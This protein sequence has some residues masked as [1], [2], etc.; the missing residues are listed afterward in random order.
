MS[1]QFLACQLMCVFF[2]TSHS[3]C[4]L[5]CVCVC[6]FKIIIIIII[7]L[8]CEFLHVKSE[9]LAKTLSNIHI[10]LVSLILVVLLKTNCM[11]GYSVTDIECEPNII[12]HSLVI[13]LGD[14]RFT[15][16]QSLSLTKWSFIHIL[17]IHDNAPSQ[18]V[19]KIR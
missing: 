14:Y 16:L 8:L 6:V 7:I 4:Q 5:T 10:Y 1:Y 3:A 18:V 12:C 2:F 15:M 17:I 19:D 13:F 11:H 9:K